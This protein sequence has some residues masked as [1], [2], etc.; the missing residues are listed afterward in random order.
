[1]LKN[2][3]LYKIRKHANEQ[4]TNKQTNKRLKPAKKKQAKKKIEHLNQTNK[5]TKIN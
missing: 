2:V 4:K 1:M 5:Q 3:L